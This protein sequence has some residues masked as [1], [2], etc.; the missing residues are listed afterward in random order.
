MCPCLGFNFFPYSLGLSA[1]FSPVVSVAWESKWPASWGSEVPIT[2][3]ARAVFLEGSS[4]LPHPC[5]WQPGAVSF[6]V[7]LPRPGAPWRQGLWLKALPHLAL[8]PFGQQEL[9][10]VFKVCTGK[11]ANPE[12]QVWH[13]RPSLPWPCAGGRRLR[14]R[15][16]P[17][18]AGWGPQ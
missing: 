3:E 18:R 9:A 6:S 10:C 7:F 1:F 16:P 8:S 14:V 12:L 17:A 4:C 2:L 15:T 13:V 11:A 5:P